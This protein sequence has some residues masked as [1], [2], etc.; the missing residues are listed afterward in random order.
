MFSRMLYATRRDG[1]AMHSR[2]MAP[3]SAA[4]RGSRLIQRQARVTCPTG[5]A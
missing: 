5:R 1:I 3:T 2:A 4:V